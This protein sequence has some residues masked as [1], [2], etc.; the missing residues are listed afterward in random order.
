MK[1]SIIIPVFD[2]EKDLEVSLKRVLSFNHAGWE[3]E[4]I[5]VNDGSSDRSLKI[6]SRI[7]K[8][9]RFAKVL[10]FETNRGKGH[11]VKE[12]LKVAS[13]EF[14]LIQ[15]ADLEYHPKDLPS[16]L[17]KAKEFDAVY[18]SR[19]L[20]DI[21]RMSFTHWFGNK[22]LS[23]ATN[24]LFGQRITDGQTGYKLIKTKLLKN[25]TLKTSGFDLDTEI[26]I[27]LL[28]RNIKICEV[29]ISYV[30]RTK[31]EKKVTI[32]DGVKAFLLLLKRRFS[33]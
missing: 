30:A 22:F 17:D 11:A 10:D 2:E 7:L 6:A 31:A 29:P 27:E 13:G 32:A 9:K 33:N 26:T 23:F 14:V 8:G 12:G 28:K 18:G 21:K 16:M 25:L 20:G 5:V 24:I 4:I 15:D 19:F 1:L 3:K